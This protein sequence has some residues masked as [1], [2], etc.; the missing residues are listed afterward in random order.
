[1][2]GKAPFV[3][4]LNRREKKVT[5]HRVY[6]KAITRRKNRKVENRE[7]LRI[8]TYCRDKFHFRILVAKTGLKKEQE[9][10]YGAK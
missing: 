2:P 6:F 1:M 7:I 8:L 5:V 9:E 4:E 3:K 10:Q